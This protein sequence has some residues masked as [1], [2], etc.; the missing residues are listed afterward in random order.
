MGADSTPPTN[1]VKLI[2]GSYTGNGIDNRE[3]NIGVNLAATYNI[4][5][6]IKS[7]GAY[8]AVHASSSA[9]NTQLFDATGNQMNMMQNFTA[10]GFEIGTADEVNKDTIEYTY[11]VFYQD[12]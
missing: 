3:I 9:I 4:W 2:T 5:M 11:N 10:N 8:R 12:R 1:F 7:E 6:I